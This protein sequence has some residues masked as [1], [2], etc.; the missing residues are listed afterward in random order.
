ML[1]MHIGDIKKK[2]NCFK[3]RISKHIIYRTK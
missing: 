3:D 2:K 1:V